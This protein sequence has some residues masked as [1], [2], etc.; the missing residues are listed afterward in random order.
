MRW[1]QLKITCNSCGLPTRLREFYYSA[2]GEV[3]VASICPKCKTVYDNVFAENHFADKARRD[4]YVLS[5]CDMKFLKDLKI[6]WE[7]QVKGSL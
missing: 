6:K 2:D 5:P 7:D 1:F 4:D 3:R